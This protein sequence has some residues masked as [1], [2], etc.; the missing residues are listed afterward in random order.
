MTPDATETGTV[1]AFADAAPE[2]TMPKA[3]RMTITDR[4]GN[5]IETVEQPKLSTPTAP[6]TTDPDPDPDPDPEPEAEDAEP[7]EPA[8]EPPTDDEPLE[9]ADDGDEPEPEKRPRTRERDRGK[10]SYVKQA[11]RYRRAA[12]RTLEEAKRER[13]EAEKL[14]EEVR[15]LETKWSE[16]NREFEANPLQAVARRQGVTADQV[17]ARYADGKAGDL[18]PMVAAKFDQM[19][20]TID[21]LKADRDE[22]ERAAEQSRR[23]N[24][25]RSRVES[26]VGYLAGVA[27]READ[28]YPFFSALPQ[29]EREQ[30]AREFVLEVTRNPAFKGW[31]R[32]D[33]LGALE[34]HA[35]EIARSMYERKP[36]S[37]WEKQDDA[38]Q[39]QRRPRKAKPSPRRQAA[40]PAPRREPTKAEL[41][42]MAAQ[43]IRRLM[44]GR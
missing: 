18:D 24:D 22:R 40:D 20:A 43:E 19:Q 12:E 41:N 31:N 17:L 2:P 29:R 6:V 23:E 3:G 10:L 33:V 42:E 35:E 37:R 15:G 13:S 30:K 38:P 21:A 4:D 14:R 28:A 8:E 11:E 16:F 25:F 32:A 39:A 27:E 34:E 26:D 5:V 44:Q 7:T 1:G 9:A 36:W